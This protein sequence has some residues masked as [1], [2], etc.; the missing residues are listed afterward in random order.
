[1][2]FPAIMQLT[3]MQLTNVQLTNAQPT[4]VRASNVRASNVQPE[5]P[6][7]CY[8]A[9]CLA[10]IIGAKINAFI[11]ATPHE[12]VLAVA[13][14]FSGNDALIE[15]VDYTLER[16][17]YVFSRWYHLKRGACCGNGCRNCPFKAIK[18]FKT[19]N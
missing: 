4:N 8:C 15:G 9:D 11:D 16:G 1:M 18:P 2:G 3:I 10:S 5:D 17:H 19:I 14:D 13:S 6:Q 7:G 12:E